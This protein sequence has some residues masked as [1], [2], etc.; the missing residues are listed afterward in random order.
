[1]RIGIVIPV[2]NE[3]ARIVSCLE[4]L[5]PLRAQGH[6]VIVVDGGSRDA[7]RALAAPLCDRLLRSR[8]GR[9]AQMNLGARFAASDVI[10]FLHA[11]CELPEGGDQA[12]AQ[13]LADREPGWGWFDSRLSARAP[14]FGII[15]ALMNLRARLTAVCTGDQ[16]LFV[17][18]ELFHTAGGFPAIPLMED[19]AISKKLRRLARPRPLARKVTSSARR[20]Q[21]D[22]A[23]RTILKMWRLRLLYFFGAAPE[24]LAASYYPGLFGAAPRFR[25]PAARIMLFARE[26]K[27]G[28]VKTRLAAHIGAEA[29]LRL[30]RAMLRRVVETIEQS[31][32]AE[33]QLWAASD[34]EHEEF[35]CL[36]DFRDIRLQEGEDIGSRMRHAAAAELAQE[37]VECVLIIGADCPALTADYLEQALEALAAG[38]DLVLGPARDGG[39]VLIGLRRSPAE[40]FRAVD[41]GGSQVLPQTLARARELGLSHQLLE[42]SWD[43]D[44][45][46][47]LPLLDTLRPPLSWSRS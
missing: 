36:C 15:A 18:A 21:R 33:F 6:E 38:I 44:D 12:I 47:D 9:A 22:G 5:R 41:W 25:Y 30:Y 24:K 40:L 2:L 14:L 45:V 10:L 42:P 16:A 35:L 39:Y 29:A 20:W 7:T 4:R 3:E 34:G 8:P 19:I 26:P 27:L 46:D 23:L 28:A 11:D 17:S 31:A 43:V 1:M 37:G 13:A 32:L